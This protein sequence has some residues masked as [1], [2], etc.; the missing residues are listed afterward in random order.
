MLNFNKEKMAMKTGANASD[1]NLIK[2]LEAEG[3]SSATISAGTGIAEK[4]VKAFMVDPNAGDSVDRS[5]DADTA[6]L[7][8]DL[9]AKVTA[10]AEDL[11]NAQAMNM[12]LSEQVVNLTSLL[13]ENEIEIP[14]E[15]GEEDE[16]DEGFGND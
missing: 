4:T 10:Q 5:I 7:I 1:Q 11:V 2:K 3:H 16:P 15:F 9:Q 12:S 6:G 8:E 13:E 14:A